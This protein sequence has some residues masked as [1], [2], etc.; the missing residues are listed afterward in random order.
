MQK[1]IDNFFGNYIVQPLAESIWPIPGINIP[2][3]VAWLLSGAIFFTV[4][5]RFVNIRLFFMR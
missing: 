4:K 2:L 3:V 5:F 1:M